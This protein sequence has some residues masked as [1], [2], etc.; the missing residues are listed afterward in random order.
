MPWKEVPWS[1]MTDEQREMMS[2][3]RVYR[4]GRK[5]RYKARRTLE[6][7]EMEKGPTLPAYGS[8]TFSSNKVKE[9]KPSQPNLESLEGYH[10]TKKP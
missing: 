2:K 9:R 8:E 3:G 1:D 6:R 5:A 7:W 4:K 10:V